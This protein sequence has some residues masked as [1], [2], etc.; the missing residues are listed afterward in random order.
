MQDCAYQP[1]PTVIPG[2]MLRTSSP[3]RGDGADHLV[4]G[5]QRVLAEA[6]FVIEH[7]EIAVADA[8]V[9]N[10]DFDVLRP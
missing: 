8:T 5:H 4:A 9:A 3:N 10:V 7:A 6:P 1:K 2:R